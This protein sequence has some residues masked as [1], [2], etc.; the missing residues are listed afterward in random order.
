[1][2]VYK[3][4]GKRIFEIVHWP[5][6]LPANQ[7]QP[8]SQF[9]WHKWCSLARPSKGQCTISEIL[10]SL[11]FSLIVEQNIYFPETCFAHTISE[12]K[13]TVCSQQIVK[14]KSQVFPFHFFKCF[15]QAHECLLFKSPIGC[16]MTQ[17]QYIEVYEFY[18]MLICKFLQYP[19]FIKQ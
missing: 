3:S 14:A 6:E 8:T 18:F 11:I 7:H 9:G 17:G 19:F 1:M 10:S 15:M 13:F 16:Y 12:L 2:N 4:M 5:L